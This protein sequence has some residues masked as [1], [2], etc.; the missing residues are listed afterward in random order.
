MKNKQTE[1]FIQFGT[2][3]FLRGFADWMIQKINDSTDF[4]GSVVMVQN[5]ENGLSD[6]LTRQHCQ[7]THILRGV[8]GVE[9]EEIKVIS[10]CVNPFADFGAYLELA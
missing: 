3:G 6:L 4:E 7:Y 10:R 1:R 5:T 2:G 8:E 9:A